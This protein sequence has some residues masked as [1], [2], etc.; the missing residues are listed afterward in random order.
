M[1]TSISP[2]GQTNN[3]GAQIITLQNAT[4]AYTLL[5]VQSG[6]IVQVPAIAAACTIT[7]PPVVNA[8]G[9]RYDIV[10]SGVLGFVLSITAPAGT[11]RGFAQ[12]K[13]ND[14]AGAY[15]AFVATAEGGSATIRIGAANFVGD[16]VSIFCD[17]TI[18]YVQG[19]SSS[20]A[21]GAVFSFV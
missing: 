15:A 3:S 9:C 21:A 1:S 11:M 12:Q 17:G 19:I 6:S 4:T 2:L 5:P 16:R 18:Y 13:S 14:A 8:V 20:A 7:L 10:C